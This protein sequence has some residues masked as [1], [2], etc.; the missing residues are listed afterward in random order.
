VPVPFPSAETVKLR[1]P[2]A[3]E[4]VQLSRG[5]LG[6]IA[7]DGPPGQLRGLLAEA[8][9]PAMTGFPFGAAEAPIDPGAFAQ[10]M[11]RRNEAFRSRIVQLVI[12]LVLVLRPIPADVVDR[13]QRLAR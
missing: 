8:V 9:V 2:D 10:G 5:I 7:A 1:P 12:L 13:A 4:A 6:I 3:E 11:A